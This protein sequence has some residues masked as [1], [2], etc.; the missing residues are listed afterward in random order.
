MLTYQDV[1]TVKLGVLLTAAKDWDDMASGF[2]DLEA[3]YAAKVE[4]VAND[5]GW[6][7]VSAGEASSRFAGTRKQLAH[8]QTETRAI[9]SLLRDAYQRLSEL[10]GHVKDLV[11]QA[12]KDEMSVNS[13]GEAVYDFSRLTPMRHDP[14]YPKHMSQ[15]K[16][17]EE[18]WT[19]KIKN[20]VQAVDAEDQIVRGALRKAAG[21]KGFFGRIR[22]PLGL[23]H[24]FN[25]AAVGDLETYEKEAKRE[26]AERRAE[27]EQRK[28]EAES[29]DE[30]LKTVLRGITRGLETFNRQPSLDLGS[31]FV[32]TAIDGLAEYTGFNNTQG[33]TLSGSLG[34][35]VGVGGDI[36]LV[37]T[38]TP[39]G[40]SQ[41]NLMYSKTA[42]S[43]GWDVGGS[44]NV[45]IVRSNADDISQLKG[46]GWDKGG[47]L[48]AGVGLWG[49][50]Q[51]AIGATN[52]KGEDVGT[53]SGGVGLGLGN[54]ISTGFSQADGWTLWEEGKKK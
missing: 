14:D 10:I 35:G 11:E 38:R 5:G 12:E 46:A 27:A 18:A 20:A 52:S 23:D 13:K 33:I 22:D 40:R 15:A 17:A 48:H 6:I 28:K 25:G 9:A 54:E 26:E 31:K 42:T 50:H 36:S 21:V 34:F 7:G 24:G 29:E 1:V 30:T 8:A 47:S 51:N 44:L 43:A 32:G 49:G 41:I 53:F 39:D 19:Q 2:E 45:G 4:A 16:E 37:H 3:L